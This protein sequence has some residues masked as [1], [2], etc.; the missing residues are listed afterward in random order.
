MQQPV[1]GT[2]LIIVLHYETRRMQSVK[3]PVRSEETIQARIMQIVKTKYY[4]NP[5]TMNKR[6][7][8]LR[9]VKDAGLSSRQQKVE[10]E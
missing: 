3:R 9:T 2:D 10:T 5:I 7:P 6:V 4:Q 1:C 8:H